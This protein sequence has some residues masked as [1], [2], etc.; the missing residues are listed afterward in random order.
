MGFGT[1]NGKTSD[2]RLHPSYSHR[3]IGE[4][5]AL[6]LHSVKDKVFPAQGGGTSRLSVMISACAAVTE[7]A[8]TQWRSLAVVTH[9]AIFR[10]PDVR[11][12]V[13]KA[14]LFHAEAR[15]FL[16]HLFMRSKILSGSL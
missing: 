2:C 15:G 6:R 8:R 10:T 14:L 7:D 4:G 5:G 11:Q 1:C 16:F 3:R 9:W 12:E 13:T